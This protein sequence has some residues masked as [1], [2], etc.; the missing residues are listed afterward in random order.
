MRKTSFKIPVTSN[1][2]TVAKELSGMKRGLEENSPFRRLLSMSI[3]CRDVS[4]LP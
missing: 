1:N 3:S 4:A 2:T